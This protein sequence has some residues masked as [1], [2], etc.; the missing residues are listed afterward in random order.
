VLRRVSCVVDATMYSGK[1]TRVH[2]VWLL[3]RGFDRP[4]V[5]WAG[6][7]FGLPGQAWA[8]VSEV[9]PG[10]VLR[11]LR[12]GLY[13]LFIWAEIVHILRISIIFNPHFSL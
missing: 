8:R 1:K 3:I 7:G 6:P 12:P 10:R 13:G 11:R 2:T 4:Q 5:I 9:G